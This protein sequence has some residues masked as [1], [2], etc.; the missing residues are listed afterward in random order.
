MTATIIDG[1][2]IAKQIR[3]DVAKEVA[4]LIKRYNIA[5]KIATI[6]IGKDP[7]SDL[8]LRL[9]DKACQEVGITSYHLEFSQDAAEDEVLR[10]V[11]KLNKDR[12]V[13]G[14]L[15]QFPIPDHLSAD[16]LMNAIYPHKDVEGMT[17][18]NMGRTLIGDEHLVPCT[19]LAALTILE[20]EKISLK[21]KEAVIVN[22]SNIVGKPLAALLLNRNAT[23]TVCHVFTKDIKPHT[24]TADILI[25]ATGIPQLITAEHVKNNAVVIDVGIVPTKDGICGD[26]YFDAVKKKA[27]KITPVPGGVGPVTVACSLT[28]MVKTYKNCVEDKKQ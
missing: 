6:K 13:H 12:T 21:G 20:H 9:R 4:Q 15:I 17:P 16:T 19:P 7:S 26:V 18:H 11:Q 23:V 25:T 10:T 22:H 27:G 14:I 2:A 3:K 24:S 8:Y 28:N 1:R 5:P